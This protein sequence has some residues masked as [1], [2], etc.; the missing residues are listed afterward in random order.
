VQG[1][2]GVQKMNAI[3]QMAA[4]AVASVVTFSLTTDEQSAASKAL[5]AVG[6][7]SKMARDF[8]VAVFTRTEG[9][10]HFWDS[11]S[12]Q[13]KPFADAVSA[14]APKDHSN[15]RMVVKAARDAA[16]EAHDVK[17]KP[18]LQAAKLKAEGA[19]E[20]LGKARD[21][22][23][24]L[25]AEA[26]ASTD[27]VAKA[28]IGVLRAQAEGKVTDLK[29]K[30]KEAHAAFTLARAEANPVKVRETDWSGEVAEAV[31]RINQ[32]MAHLPDGA[33][34]RRMHRALND[35]IAMA[36]ACEWIKV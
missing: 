23:E 29:Q 5:S 19:A 16:K 20:A 31:G 22:V 6:K 1:K 7:A 33:F 24:A 8:G 15:V 36:V 13:Y 3:Q 21:R 14:L 9:A 32:A 4:S 17:T 2:K 28:K 35:L 18:E 27:P 30:E 12:D 26:K 10:V 11:G 34:D 25:K